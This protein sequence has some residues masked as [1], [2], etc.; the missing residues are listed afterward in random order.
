MEYLKLTEK[1]EKLV[2]SNLSTKDIW[3]LCFWEI[4]NR[5]RYYYFTNNIK[6]GMRP[7][8]A[9]EDTLKFKFK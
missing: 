3:I 5:K 8:S 2:I 7:I 4:F 9:Y 1:E 6:R